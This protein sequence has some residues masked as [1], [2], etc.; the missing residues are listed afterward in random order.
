MG[1]YR[2][3]RR[4]ETG[5]RKDQQRGMKRSWTLFD[6]LTKKRRAY[7][8]VEDEI[9][10][11][12]KMSLADPALGVKPTVKINP[13]EEGKAR[14]HWGARL[15]SFLNGFY[16]DSTGKRGLGRRRKTKLEE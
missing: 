4:V 10:A 7:L 11:W 13:F 1:K 16:R 5:N 2:M 6:P 9:R 3:N 14:G 15:S 12:N 8:P